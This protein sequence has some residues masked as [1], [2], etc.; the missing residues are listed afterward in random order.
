MK[1]ALATEILTQYGGGERVLD[2]FL[3][4]WP[5]AP[6]FTLVYDPNKMGRYYGRY[7]VRPSFIQKLPGM[8]SN[9]KWSLPLM[10]KATESFDFSEF[11]VVL[12]NS[13]A[14]IKGIVT[15]PPTVHVA[16]VLTPTRYLWS[17]HDEYVQNAPIPGWLRPLM[18][19]V[20]AYLKWWDLRAAQRADVMIGD[21]KTVAH[22]IKKYYNRTANG[23]I[24][25]PVDTN[26]FQPA[27]K[28]GDY[29]LVVAR[30]EPYKRTDLAIA[31]AVQLGLKLVVAG[32]GTRVGE[33]QKLAGPTIT[34]VG[35][36]SD[37]E[38]AKLY[39]EAIGLIFPQEE[40]AG[41]TPL[42]SMAAGRPVLA[43]GQGGAKETVV[44]GQT[45]E[46]FATQTVAS[47]AEA[48]SKFDPGR[49]D[50]A[51][52]R[53]HAEQFDTKVFQTKIRQ[54]VQEAYANSHRSR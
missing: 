26:R 43:Y 49:Y 53:H 10:P 18:P 16:Y 7:D 34:F 54:V 38:L 5:E 24:F 22:R 45:G 37:E 15:R 19:P 31:A 35:R 6:I 2:A 32:G 30:Q 41:I 51:K 4:I 40:D 25:P 33:L 29:W 11:D 3:G 36:V 46:F 44:P 50:S 42:E 9:Y 13:S 14:Y 20:F 39:A 27:K 8:P 48:L 52:I 1:I 47:L 21:S 23:A 12:S 28:I 17:D